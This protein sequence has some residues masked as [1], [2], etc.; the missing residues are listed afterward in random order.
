MDILEGAPVSSPPSP[1]MPT[2][3][4]PDDEDKKDF[5]SIDLFIKKNSSWQPWGILFLLLENRVFLP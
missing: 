1:A 5:M 2:S 4:M 3:P